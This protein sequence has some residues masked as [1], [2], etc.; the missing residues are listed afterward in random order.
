MAAKEVSFGQAVKQLALYKDLFIAVLIAGIVFIIVIPLPPLLLDIF[1]TLSITL[2]LVIFFTTM[3]TASALQ[4]SIFPSL[5]L[6]VTLFRLALNISSARLILSQGEAGQ[7]IEAF[8]NFVIAGNYVVGFII[9]AIITIVQFVVITNGAGRVAE[10]AA[11]FT[12][13]SIPGKQMSIDADLNA[14]LISEEEARERRRNLQRETDFYGAMDGASKFV[15]GDAIAG[16]IITLINILGGLVIGIWQLKLPIAEALHTY[17]ILTV[18]DGLVTQI[19]ALLVSTGAGILVTRSGAEQNLG[20][21]LSR[22]LTAFP[23]LIVLVALIL[24][25]LGLVPGLPK[26]PFFL[27]AGATWYV[28]QTLLRESK[29]VE[30]RKKEEQIVATRQRQPENVL[31]LLQTEP[32][33]VEIGYNLIPLAD[34]GHGGDL[35]ERLAAVRRQCALE[36]GIFVRP[37]RVR[38]NLQLTPNSYVF[39]IRGVETG[40]G[41]ILPGYF[42]AMG[43]GGETAPIKGIS[44]K[45]PTFGLPA[46]WVTHE[47][48]DAVEL[49]GY[50]VVDATTVLVTHLTEFIK[51][52]AHELLGRQEVKEMVE[53]VRENNAAAV[54]ELIPDLMTIGEI[55]KVLQN[56]L[57]ERVPIRNLITILEGLADHAR[58]NKDPDYLTEMV[59]Q[60]LYRVISNL[61]APLGNLKVITL[62]P[63]LERVIAESV[64]MTREGNYPVLAADITRRFI[65]KLTRLAEEVALSGQQPV[66]LSASRIRLP[67]KRLVER[68]IPNL[69]VLAFNEL[70]PNL[71]VEAVGTVSLLED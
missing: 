16:L 24:L 41:E 2:S 4:F 25:V 59:R 6:V 15:R 33:E 26:L 48:K 60:S 68:F 44:T 20:Q 62:H 65:E 10:V 47:E 64:Q 35:L 21:D 42:L 9:F 40:R 18:G 39:K 54:E 7:V 63:E 52:H 11:R 45:E 58:L 17:T 30:T 12:L 43:I 55:Q 49:S 38:D 23:R 53:V 56:L 51:A 3:F 50:T 70:A 67:L 29:Q 71:E 36:L 27:L 19:P 22:Q 34:E 37:I 31:G 14:G 1:L 13:D 69:V 61:Y 66:M 32:L 28:A 8:G 57:K 46:W 5:L